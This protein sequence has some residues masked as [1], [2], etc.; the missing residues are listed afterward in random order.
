VVQFVLVNPHSFILLDVTENG[1]TTTW[2]AELDGPQGLAKEFGWTPASTKK[3]VG[4][5]FTVIGR[6]VK[7]GA[8]Y[9]NLTERANIVLTDSGQEIFRAVNFGQPAPPDE[10]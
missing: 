1:T 4:S 8:P 10:K 3:W 6:R 9:I 7:S 2:T 5:R